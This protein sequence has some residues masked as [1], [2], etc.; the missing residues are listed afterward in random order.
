MFSTFSR[1]FVFSSLFFL[2]CYGAHRDLHSFPTRRS[3]D[4]AHRDAMCTCAAMTRSQRSVFTASDS[5]SGNAAAGVKTE[6][7]ERSEEHTS[8]LQSHSDLVCRLLL[9]KKK[10]HKHTTKMQHEHIHKTAS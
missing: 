3:S 4:L 1:F 9:E 10:K 5:C 7:W 6:R 8:E 2:Y